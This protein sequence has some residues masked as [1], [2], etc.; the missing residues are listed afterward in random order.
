MRALDGEDSWRDIDFSDS[1]LRARWAAGLQD[2][3]RML[4]RAPWN[5][6]ARD[7]VGMR[8]HTLD[9]AG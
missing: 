7:R 6:P 5:A 9:D 4:E 1:R 2:G 3:R 8:V